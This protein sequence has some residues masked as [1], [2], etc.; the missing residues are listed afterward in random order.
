MVAPSVSIAAAST[1]SSEV[2]L[3]RPM[4]RIIGAW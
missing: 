4:V 1:P 3:I 2:P